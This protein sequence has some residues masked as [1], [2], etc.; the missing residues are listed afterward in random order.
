MITTRGQPRQEE[1]LTELHTPE[2]RRQTMQK[3]RRAMSADLAAAWRARE[4]M[5]SAAA[6]RAAGLIV[7]LG[8]IKQAIENQARALGY[9]QR[10]RRAIEVCRG[11]CCL[12]HF[13]KTISVV[14]FFIAVFDF[15][16]EETAALAAQIRA[17]AGGQAYQC[18]LLRKDG[19]IFDFQNRPLVCTSAFPCMAGQQFWQYKER[20]R[21]DIATLRT[22][23]GRLIFDNSR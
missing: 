11:E 7:E 12:W 9:T 14:D 23:L 6:A 19:C 10:C 15:A 16:E 2:E 18:P 3:R 8:S 17:G 1:T 21:A 22:D 13:P 5:G 20:F 4:Q